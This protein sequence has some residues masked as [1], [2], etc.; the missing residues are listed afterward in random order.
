MQA[1]Q[2]MICF[3]QHMCVR[4]GLGLWNDNNNE[5]SMHCAL[6]WISKK[7]LFSSQ[8]GYQTKSYFPPQLTFGFV[9]AVINQSVGGKNGL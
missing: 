7:P 8:I 4:N 6:A 2:T 1:M 5:T 3:L 9:S